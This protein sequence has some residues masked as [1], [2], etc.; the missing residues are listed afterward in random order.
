MTHTGY[1]ELFPRKAA[2]LNKEKL[3]S[4]HHYMMSKH[5]LSGA[6]HNGKRPVSPLRSLLDS[7]SGDRLGPVIAFSCWVTQ[8]SCRLQWSGHSPWLLLLNRTHSGWEP[9][10]LLACSHPFVHVPTSYF[11]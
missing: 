2:G 6:H 11:S 10:Y 9:S 8:Q 5:L 3:N 7:L 1:A 4:D